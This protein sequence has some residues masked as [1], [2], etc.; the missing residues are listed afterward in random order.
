MGQSQHDKFPFESRSATPRM[1]ILSVLT[2]PDL[3]D[4]SSVRGV[5]F[6]VPIAQDRARAWPAHRITEELSPIA[7][8]HTR[9]L[10]GVCRISTVL[11]I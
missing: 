10:T 6:G 5:Y 8:R 11:H 1:A 3:G 9:R 2:L 7:N 4:P